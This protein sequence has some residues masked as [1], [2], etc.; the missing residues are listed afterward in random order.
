MSYKYADLIQGQ[1]ASGKSV[2]Q[3][4]LLLVRKPNRQTN[5]RGNR[6]RKKYG[7]RLEGAKSVWRKA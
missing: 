2:T 5:S 7:F 1:T 3:G 6:M 4:C